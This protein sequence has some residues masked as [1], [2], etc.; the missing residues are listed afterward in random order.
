MRIQ[1][2]PVYGEGL[3]VI[4]IH[5]YPLLFFDKKDEKWDFVV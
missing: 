1:E 4:N 3:W 2:H 5:I